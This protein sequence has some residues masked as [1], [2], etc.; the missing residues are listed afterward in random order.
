MIKINRIL[1]IDDDEISNF[2]NER[3]LKS[4]AI[5]DH[6]DICIS[7]IKGLQLLKEIHERNE[8]CPEIILLDINMPIMDGFGFLDQF[9]KLPP[10]FINNI[11]IAML[12]SSL[13]KD[14]VRR[15]FEY[16]NVVDFIN[17]PLSIDKIVA[18]AIKMNQ[19]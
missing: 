13:E 6:I 4:S 19:K 15:S 18:L 7:G 12:T 5:A 17:K 1:L 10:E 16:K 14:E 11:R 8:P 3:K 2:I 9:V